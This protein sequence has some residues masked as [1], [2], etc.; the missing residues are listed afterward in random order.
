MNAATLIGPSSAE[1]L[2]P[3]STS[4]VVIESLFRAGVDVFRLN[5]IEGLI[6]LDTMHGC[7]STLSTTGS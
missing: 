2:G 4:A 5:A 1:T 7:S 3:A 6:G